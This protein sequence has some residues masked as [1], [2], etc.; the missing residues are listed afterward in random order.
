[1]FC[2]D[3]S[4]DSQPPSMVTHL[5]PNQIQHYCGKSENYENWKIREMKNIFDAMIG[6][7]DFVSCENRIVVDIEK[8]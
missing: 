6:S 2:A 3:L 8:C 7:L 5:R 4:S 1:M